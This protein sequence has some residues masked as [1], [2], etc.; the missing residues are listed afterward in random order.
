MPESKIALCAT[1][2]HSG[3][4]LKKVLDPIFMADFP[5]DHWQAIEAYSEKLTED[6]ISVCRQA[7]NNRSPGLLSWG[8]G[9]VGFAR[10]RRVI[11]N[12]KWTGFGVQPDGAV[13]HSLPVLKVSD[14]EGNQIAVLAS[15]ACH[16]TTL[17]GSFN[18]VHGDWAGAAQRIIEEENSGITAMIAI[19]CG[20]D[21]NPFPRGNFEN[22]IE[23]ATQLA[24]EV[25]RLL[26]QDLK[27]LKRATTTQIDH[28]ELPLDPL[29][30]RSF[31][32]TEIASESRTAYYARKILE[33]MDA[34][35]A[36]PRSIE[37]PI[38]T[39]T[40]GDD[41]AIVFLA[42]EVVVDYALKIKERIDANRVWVNA[43][44]NASPSYIPSRKMY[45][46][47]GYEVD[48]S[49]YYY[50]KPVRLGPDTEDLVLDEVIQQLPRSYYSET[51][52]RALPAPIAKE[53]AL[54]TFQV[55]PDLEIEMVASEPL[56]ADPIDIA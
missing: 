34:G 12:G 41:L 3:P 22:V 52:L 26:A 5:P 18:Q 36:L 56:I 53:N 9:K 27:P 8:Q 30:E 48:R 49:M 46:E 45:D 50:D 37:Y 6:V 47:G 44:A 16:C 55:H 42:G 23:N 28:I 32:E 11:E 15:Y 38:Q 29:P 51:T 35:E 4:H 14:H 10:N 31:W 25:D 19:G 17:G 13:D 54:S 40:F 1:H 7:I 2:T 20:A 21:A 39:W 33:R 24:R 43:Y